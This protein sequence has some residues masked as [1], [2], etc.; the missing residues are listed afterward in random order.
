ME[1]S[2]RRIVGEAV[3]CPSC[4]APVEGGLRHCAYCGGPVAT[5]RC[6][7]CFQ[8]NTPDATYCSGCGHELGLEP[9]GGPALLQCPGCSLALC[10]F[11][12]GPG[13]L[14]DCA[15]CGGQ[16]VEHALLRDLLLRREVCGAAVPRRE[17]GVSRPGQT[18][19][20]LPCPGCKAL[21]NRH[22]FGGTSGVIVD[23]C[24]KHG[25]W[26]DA[27]EL[28]RVLDF[29]EA[30]GLARARRVEL[31]RL[32]QARRQIRAQAASAEL[33]G[34]AGSGNSVDAADLARSALGDGSSALAH[35]EPPAWSTGLWGD[36]KDAVTAVLHQLGELLDK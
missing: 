13:R 1:Q 35:K 17:T 33:A 25:V 12:G 6:S 32:E 18:V 36:A 7:G 26:F 15:R 27:G 21:M 10:A 20:Y 19:R 5:V 2:D 28:P 3:A 22:N 30:G 8:M 34:M 24:S 11:A 16:L 14:Y 31:E 23:I 9:I 29:V 4:G